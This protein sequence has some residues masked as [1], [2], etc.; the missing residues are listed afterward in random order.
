MKDDYINLLNYY[1]HEYAPTNIGSSNLG[2]DRPG[3]KSTYTMN[4]HIQ[5]FNLFK[6]Y[7]L[8]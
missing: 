8:N 7:F 4:R 1:N 2:G 6:S 5:L 3:G